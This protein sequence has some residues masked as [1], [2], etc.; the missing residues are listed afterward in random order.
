[1]GRCKPAK[2]I[3]VKNSNA[4]KSGYAIIFTPCKNIR[5]TKSCEK[6]NKKL[7]HGRPMLAAPYEEP[8]QHLSKKLWESLESR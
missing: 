8:S 2:K 5:R 1:L 6:V 7:Q 4:T 3:H